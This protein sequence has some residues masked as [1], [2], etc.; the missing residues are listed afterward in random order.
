LPNITIDGRGLTPKEALQDMWNR[1]EPLTKKGYNPTSNVEI[2]DARTRKIIEHF[3][4]T[5]PD[6]LERIRGE[7]PLSGAS[8]AARDDHKPPMPHEYPFVARINLEG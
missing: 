1:M 4:V 3:P 8:K 2:L 5:D 6:F 7:P